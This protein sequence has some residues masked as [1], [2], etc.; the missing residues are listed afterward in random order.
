MSEANEQRSGESIESL[1][2]G[3]KDDPAIEADVQGTGLL[4]G[5]VRKID[6]RI[7]DLGKQAER[8]RKQKNYNWENICNAQILGLLI[9]RRIV[10]D[11]PE[12][13]LQHEGTKPSL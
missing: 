10:L 1:C 12:P 4:Q 11:M 3:A 8:E 5:I 6:E 7:N 2:S 9:A 13:M